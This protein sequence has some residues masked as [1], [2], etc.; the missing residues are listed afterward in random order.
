[1]FKFE[2][3]VY[4]RQRERSRATR[5]RENERRAKERV[6]RQE[7]WRALAS[8]LHLPAYSTLSA[9]PLEIPAI[10]HASAVPPFSIVTFLLQEPETTGLAS[11]RH[12]FSC[13]VDPAV[14]PGS[15]LIPLYPELC[16][17]V[18]NKPPSALL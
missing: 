17:V 18:K 16:D 13:T 2:L 8:R 10:T 12:Q 9:G 14:T 6:G 4:E 11:V 5:T 1:M 15:S 7:R 3:G